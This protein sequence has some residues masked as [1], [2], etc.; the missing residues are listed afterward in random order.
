MPQSVSAKKS[1]RQNLRN[2]DRNR[3]AKSVIRLHIRKLLEAISANDAAAAKEQFRFVVKKTD[4]AA[5]ARTIHPNRAARIKSRLSARL[6]AA[7]QTAK[8]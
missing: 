7:F 6:Q 3:A 8:A 4:R 2:R 5:S 1:L